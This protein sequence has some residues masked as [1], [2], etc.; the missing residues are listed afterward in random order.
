MAQQQAA[1]Q[2]QQ[3]YTPEQIAAI[4]KKLESMKPEEIQ[5]MIKK[6][7]VFC[8][9]LKGE[10]PTFPVWEDEKVFATLEI[11]PAN[12]G[13]VLVFPKEH[14]TVLP[15]MPDDLV[16]HLFSVVK[17]ISAV[18]FEVTGAEGV[19]VRQR[20][21]AAAGQMIPHVHVHVIPRF[22]KD[23]VVTDW[24][25]KQFAEADFQKIQAVLT[26]KSKDI[27]YHNPEVKIVEKVVSAPA[28]EPAPSAPSPKPARRKP[29][30][31]LNRHP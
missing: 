13:H 15:Q 1:P 31:R 10:I 3:Q 12:E 23:D 20:N 26:D 2:G 7:C 4:K 6:Q 18:V 17:Q 28:E 27:K 22:Q 25:P 9:I 30:P 8:R 5:D 21:G 11:Q 16:A 14:H 19:E 29:T 24:T